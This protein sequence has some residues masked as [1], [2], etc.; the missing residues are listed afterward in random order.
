MITISLKFATGTMTQIT[1]PDYKSVKKALCASGL[2][3][4]GN[5]V[6]SEIAENPSRGFTVTNLKLGK[7]QEYVI[8]LLLTE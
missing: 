8:Y 1:M 4:Y 6:R 2:E 3:V 7:N 5:W